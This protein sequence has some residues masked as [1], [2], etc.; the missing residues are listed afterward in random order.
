VQGITANM[1]EGTLPE[2]LEASSGIVV[3]R[4]VLR[5]ADKEQFQIRTNTNAR[6]PINLNREQLIHL[7]V[8]ANELLSRCPDA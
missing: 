5:Y 7:V 2:I 8:L 1:A 3:E 4:Y 6:Y